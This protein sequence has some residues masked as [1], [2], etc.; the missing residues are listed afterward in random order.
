MIEVNVERKIRR[1]N[2]VQKQVVLQD[3]SL[4]IQDNEVMLV[5]APSGA[6]KTTLFNCILNRT[7]FKGKVSGNEDVAYVHQEETVDRRETVMEAIYYAGY[8]SD[9]YLSEY[10][11]REKAKDIMK[12]LG[13]SSVSD[14]KIKNLSGGQRRRVQIGSELARKSSVLLLDE[15]DSGLD[16]LT[17]Y[18]LTSDLR[19]LAKV[20]N[21][22]IVV[23]SHNVMSS[24]LKHYD[25]I[26]M[27]LY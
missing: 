11:A 27:L 23:I 22:S 24:N 4:Q 16:V 17:S 8:L 9:P 15:P 21:K 25:Q 6:G 19:Q 10:K 1:K 2:L 26:L 18:H 7:R 13:L 3:V 12:E 20:S 14:K 5:L